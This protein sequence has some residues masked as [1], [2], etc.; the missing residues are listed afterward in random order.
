MPTQTFHNLPAARKEAFLA[1]SFDEFIANDYE[2]AS[3]SAIVKRL[4]IGK[5]SVYRYFEDK[6]ELYYY[7]QEVAQN[8]KIAF[9]Q[10]VL[11]QTQTDF[12]DMYRALF[13]AGM[14]FFQ[15]YPRYNQFLYNVSQD[16]SSPDLGDMRLVHK[17]LAINTF[18]PQIE[19]RQQN[20]QLRA[21]IDAETMAYMVVAASQMTAD[22]I[23]IKHKT[24]LE[25]ALESGDPLD[26]T[27]TE[28]DRLIDAFILML[29]EGI[30]LSTAIPHPL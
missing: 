11:D 30:S 3:V 26:L 7:L 10:D 16:H 29:K 4:G 27:E 15:A 20:G 12:F 22:Y 17:S 8:Q 1:A 21:D 23:L 14:K 6:K 25:A 24:A 9:L 2:R 18:I 28:M 13:R 5:G 19:A